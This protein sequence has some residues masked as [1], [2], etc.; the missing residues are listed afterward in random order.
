MV[1]ASEGREAVLPPVDRKICARVGVFATK[2]GRQGA[3][4]TTRLR[5]LGTKLIAARATGPGATLARARETTGM[6]S[7]PLSV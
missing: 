7:L 3:C 5:T 4:G 2:Q 6:T 1:D